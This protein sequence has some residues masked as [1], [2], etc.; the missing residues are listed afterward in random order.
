MKNYCSFVRWK[1]SWNLRILCVGGDLG[2]LKPCQRERGCM[3]TLEGD[4]QRQ[5]KSRQN[6][7][8]LLHSNPEILYIPQEHKGV[9]QGGIHHGEQPWRTAGSTQLRKAW[10]NITHRSTRSAVN[11]SK[12]WV[13]ETN[14]WEIVKTSKWKPLQ[15]V[16]WFHKVLVKCLL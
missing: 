15:S 10:T 12:G 1:K 5:W 14:T 3:T 13:M 11:R 6:I 8:A 2:D 7:N 9:H 4:L 16:A